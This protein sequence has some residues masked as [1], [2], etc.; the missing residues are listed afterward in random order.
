MK[1]TIDIS[2]REPRPS[3]GHPLSAA[4]KNSLSRG[5]SLFTAALL[6]GALS[7]C[8]VGP[9][10]HPPVVQPPAAFKQPPA[11][12]A[13]AGTWTVAQ[14]QD[15]KIRGNWWEIFNDAELNSLES[16]LNINNQ[17]IKV[18]FENFMQA[19][20]LIGEARAQYY[21]TAGTTPAF[22]RARS[23]SNLSNTPSANT[24]KESTIYSLPID[25]SWAPDLWGRVR[26]AVHA[27]QYSAQV[28]AADLENEKLIEQASLAEYFFE[29]RGQDALI[30]L[31]DETI[32]ADT[33]T[34][35][36]TQ[37]LY[38]TGIGDYLAV[39]EAQSTLQSVQAE[40]TNL[41]IFRAQYE[42]AIA[43]L[44]GKAA[45]D[46]SVPVRP[47]TTAPPS[48][49]IGLP[50][51]LLERRPDV[52]AAERLMAADNARL[53]IAYTA[54]YPTLTLS[55]A[56]GMQSSPFTRLLDW[57]S[58]FWSIGPSISQPLFQAGLT[59]AL[60]QYV[61]IYNA[62][63]ANYRQTI[64]TAFQQVEDSL[65][66]TQVLSTQIQQQQQAIASAQKAYDLEMV[67][68]Q[69][70]VDPYLDVV[71]LQNTLLADQQALAN[72][73][74]EQMSNAVLLV[75]ALGGGWDRTQLPTPKEVSANPPKADTR[76]QR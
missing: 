35:N 8:T 62:D 1:R 4:F 21:P 38:D 72:L 55:V 23:S 10:Y 13:G 6:C 66:A 67:R 2:R 11:P 59:S 51:E 16:Q 71:V 3:C 30:R 45:P 33:Q 24:G 68:Y 25:I 29:I 36:L 60:H 56:G 19:R 49:P 15:S 26:N 20:A 37:A 74:V 34:L 22:N 47:L 76:I 12:P 52:A 31:Y 5:R 18:A 65:T 41:T 9:K 61:A 17:N 53:G 28:S 46:F 69:T 73:Q 54:F 57:P 48:I 63:V 50:S 58:R 7:G 43:V 44:V 42:H 27:S 39:A 64:L 70:G 40:A 75:E 14:P 32:S